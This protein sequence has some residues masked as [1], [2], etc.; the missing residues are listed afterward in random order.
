MLEGESPVLPGHLQ[1]LV[2]GLGGTPDEAT[3]RGVILQ[4][5]RW[6][7]LSAQALAAVLGRRADYISKKYLRPMV[8]EGLIELTIPD[9]PRSRPSGIQDPKRGMTETTLKPYPE[10]RD[11]GHDWL[12]KIPAHW[13]VS[14]NGRLFSQRVE[15]DRPELPVLEVSLKTGVRVREPGNG[16]KQA[17]SDR[18]KYKVARWGDIAYNMMRMWQGAV[19]VAP[20]AGLVSPAYV[21]AEPRPGTISRYYAYLFRTQ[22]Y[23]EEVNRRSR[24]IVSDRNRLYW[25]DFKQLPALLPLPDEQAQ[26]ADYLDAHRAGVDRLLRTKRQLIA[27]LDEQKQAIIQRAV[28]RGLDPD[29]RLKPSGVD[30]LGEVPAHW[31][32]LPLKRVARLKSGDSITA[33]QFRDH[34]AYPVY[35][36]NG[37]R[38]YTDD[39]THDGDYVLIGRQGALCGNVNY[40]RGKF[41]A[42][43]HAVVSTLKAGYDLTW[44]GETVRT[45]NLNQ[46]SLS[47]AQPGLSV[48]R[49]QNV[50]A[51]IPPQEE[52]RAIAEYLRQETSGIEATIE[53]AQEEINLIREYRAR[54]IA[55]VV[56]GKLDVRDVAV[57]EGED[58]E[59][60]VRLDAADGEP[61]PDEEALAEEDV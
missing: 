26:I 14:R 47:A 42:S 27:L 24:G 61:A 16:R 59:A 3:M 35:G 44:F 13:E 57:P 4:L 36:G 10:Y 46:Y 17:M 1:E 23:M 56:T 48:E 25:H 39:Y 28:T 22:A 30:W 11:S 45:M 12:G 52:Q 43:E 5:C 58:A 32:V 6:R 49:I 38:G 51:P 9:K 19:G 20:V 8:A 18:S 53:K 41:W 21:V 55:E 7:P 34:G 29:V 15:T 60:D 2:E 40:A 50:A 31:E 37:L 54:L 33:T